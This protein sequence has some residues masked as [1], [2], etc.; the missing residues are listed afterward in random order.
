MGAIITLFVMLFPAVI[1]GG[2]IQGSIGTKT[3]NLRAPIS[4]AAY[5]VLVLIAFA[6]TS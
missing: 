3:K 5:I 2:L 6:V 4:I 1:I